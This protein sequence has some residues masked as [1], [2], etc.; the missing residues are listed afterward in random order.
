MEFPIVQRSQGD[1]WLASDRRVASSLHALY[2]HYL[3]LP[4]PLLPSGY[5][6]LN[7]FVLIARP[8]PE[9]HFNVLLP[10]GTGTLSLV[11]AAPSPCITTFP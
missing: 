2:L 10:T 7:I 8:T 4:L 5:A 9:R 6:R 1:L 11:A 3:R